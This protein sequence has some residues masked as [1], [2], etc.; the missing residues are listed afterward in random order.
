MLYLRALMQQLGE[1]LSQ[2]SVQ[3]QTHLQLPTQE[4]PKPEKYGGDLA[5][6]RGFLLQ[7]HLYFSAHTGM[8]EATKLTHFH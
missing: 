3:Q 2:L 8:N 5:K 4:L 7:C 6:C 1:E